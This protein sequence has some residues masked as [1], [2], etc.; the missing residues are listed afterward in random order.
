MGNNIIGIMIFVAVTGLAASAL[1]ALLTA[2]GEGPKRIRRALGG[3]IVLVVA[4]FVL[5]VAYES[6]GGLFGVAIVCAIVGAIVWIV[7]GFMK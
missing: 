1:G 5:L 2:K 7:R 3:A 6:A 4:G